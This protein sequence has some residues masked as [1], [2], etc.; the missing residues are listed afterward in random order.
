M[1]YIFF[2]FLFA[3]TTLSGQIHLDKY[4]FDFEN[5]HSYNEF[6]V[7]F[8]LSNRGS[9]D[10]YILRVQNPKETAIRLSTDLLKKDSVTVLRVQVNPSK[11]GKFSYELAIFTSDKHEPTKLT[12]V[13]DVKEFPENNKTFL[14]DCP[15]FSDKPSMAVTDFKMTVVTIDDETKEVLAQ[16]EVLLLQNGIELTKQTTDKNGK[17]V[18]S[19]PLGF[20][21]F[22]A[23]HEGYQPNEFGVYVNFNR[24]KLVIPLKKSIVKENEILTTIVSKDSVNQL[25]SGVL[26]IMTDPLPAIKPFEAIEFSDF[27]PLYFKPVNVV[28]VLD[29]SSSMLNGERLELM[30]HSLYKL[31]DYLRPEDKIGIITY[32][33]NTSVLLQP[34]WM[35]NINRKEVRKLVEKVKVGGNTAGGLGIK[36]GFELASTGFVNGSANQVIII[37]DGAFNKETVNYLN[38][39][40]KYQAQGIIMSVVGIKNSSNDKLKM[41]E[42][43]EKGKGRYVPIFK[44]NDAQINLIQ[45]IRKASYK[46]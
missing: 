1:K 35:K 12:V 26:E 10:A 13:G 17:M 18:A 44:L 19:I 34:E 28:F 39:I 4:K 5:L 9:K 6:Y 33:S 30:K 7:D 42:V 20:T 40:D 31:I 46:G 23:Q 11:L 21:Y 16:S 45:E 29:I 2:F 24:N 8:L 25:D 27:D 38:L 36:K 37:T 32:A 3:T 15:N 14:K 43:A 22:Y 41:I